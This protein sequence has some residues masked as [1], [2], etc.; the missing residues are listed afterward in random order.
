M[1]RHN[2]VKRDIPTTSK[3]SFDWNRVILITN[4]ILTMSIIYLQ[5]R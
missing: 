5:L 4:L 3:K 1:A 2:Q